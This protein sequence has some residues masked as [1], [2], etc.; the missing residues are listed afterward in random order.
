MSKWVNSGRGKKRKEPTKSYKKYL[1]LE[2]FR[3]DGWLED[4][5]IAPNIRS[6]VWFANCAFDCGTILWDEIATLDHHPIPYRLGG[7]WEISNLRLACHPCNTID[8]GPNGKMSYD[9]PSGLSNKQRIE[10]YIKYEL[11]MAELNAAN[12]IPMDKL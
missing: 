8:G 12:G 11:E 3:R 7:E 5:E 2:C 6:K 9:M 1:R 10:W 4:I